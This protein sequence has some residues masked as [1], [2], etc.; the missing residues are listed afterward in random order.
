MRKLTFPGRDNPEMTVT[1]AAGSS[2]VGP[3]SAGQ[4]DHVA[5]G[6]FRYP[7]PLAEGACQRGLGRQRPF[8][9][10][11]APNRELGPKRPPCWYPTDRGPIIPGRRGVPG[12]R[13][14]A[15][16]HDARVGGLRSRSRARHCAGLGEQPR[17]DAAALLARTK[18]TGDDD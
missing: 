13:R 14:P 4:A 16:A 1:I 9:G 17:V 10:A 2:L 18:E 8:S 12:R 15:A 5:M 7:L 3:G 6:S 11:A